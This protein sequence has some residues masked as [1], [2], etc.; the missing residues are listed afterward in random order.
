M[1][2]HHYVTP[3]D[4]RVARLAARLSASERESFEEKAAIRTHIGE[5]ACEQAEIEALL[6]VLSSQPAKPVRVFRLT[7]ADNTSQ[8][9][10][11]FDLAPA[12][13]CLQV[14]GGSDIAE[15]ELDD[16]LHQQFGGVAFLG[17]SA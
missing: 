1:D 12:L 4:P 14:L 9:V 5:L 15:A 13:S 2:D 16:V 6:D 8:W 3:V 10:L 7:L 17:T 11:A